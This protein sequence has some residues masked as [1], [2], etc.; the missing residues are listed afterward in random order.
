MV[1]RGLVASYLTETIRYTGH[2]PLVSTCTHIYVQQRERGRLG[3]PT[4][5]PLLSLSEPFMLQ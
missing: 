4:D 3:K 1:P 2:Q 5:I